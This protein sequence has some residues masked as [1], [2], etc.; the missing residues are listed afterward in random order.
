MSLDHAESLSW[1]SSLLFVWSAREKPFIQEAPESARNV[2][3]TR[4]ARYEGSMQALPVFDVIKHLRIPRNPPAIT[5][6]PMATI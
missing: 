2:I 6:H 1:S 3:K 5:L 4:R